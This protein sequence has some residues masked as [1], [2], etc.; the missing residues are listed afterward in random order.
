MSA[1]T[2]GGMEREDLESLR[3]A[4]AEAQAK[5]RTLEA[6]R[7]AM[8]LQNREMEAE[9]QAM[10]AELQSMQS[11]HRELG[12]QQAALEAERETICGVAT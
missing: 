8:E 7:Q 10:E 9:R 12:L 2:D 11:Q 3:R 5:V 1:T 4:L 6:E